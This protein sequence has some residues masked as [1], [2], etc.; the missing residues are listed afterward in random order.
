M[1]DFGHKEG[2]AFGKRAA[3]G[4]FWKKTGHDLHIASCHVQC[5]GSWNY[6]PISL[7]GRNSLACI[8]LPF[9]RK[10]ESE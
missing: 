1:T 10:A 7:R 8:L 9:C 2:R 4:V 6:C 5:V 3:R